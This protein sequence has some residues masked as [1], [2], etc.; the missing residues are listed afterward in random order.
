MVAISRRD[1]LATAL[2]AVVPAGPAAAGPGRAW[3]LPAGEALAAIEREAALVLDAREPW[4]RAAEPA[5]PGAAPVDW[6]AFADPTPGAGGRLLDDDAE[7]GR[8]LRA[9]G[10]RAGRP[11][12][13][14]G[15]PLRGWGE[16][17]RVAWTLRALGH[18]AAFAVDG[19]LP[20]LLRAAGGPPAPAPADPPGDFVVSRRP[21]LVATRE[22]LRAAL[23]AGRPGVAV[24][25]GREPR[26]FAGATPYGESRGGHVPGARH[27]WYRELM[28]PDGTVLPP[29]RVRAR[30]AALGVGEG[31]EVVAYCTLGLRAGWLAA[32]LNGL[33]YRARNYAGSMAEWSAGD[34]ALH[35]L[36]TGP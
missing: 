9:L 31:A 8:R 34:P 4:L 30:L 7:L 14:L 16:D 29:E 5:P 28:A 25:D 10:V 22:G 36:A 33:G 11:V 6:A 35:P 21:D 18:G 3:V 27:L 26:E 32:V 13:A 12:V 23:A 2:A 15:D 19:G 17:G 1:V 24:L 20:A